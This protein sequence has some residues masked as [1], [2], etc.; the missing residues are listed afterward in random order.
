MELTVC[1]V[2]YFFNDVYP[3]LYNNH[4]PLDPPGWWMRI[5]E[6]PQAAPTN[7]EGDVAPD[8]N[9]DAGAAALAPEVQHM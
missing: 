4:R 3:S 1:I 8:A 7:V 5:F 6:R 2:W 9:A